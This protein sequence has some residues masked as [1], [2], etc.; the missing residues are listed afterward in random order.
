MGTV[1]GKEPSFPKQ[2][3]SISSRQLYNIQNDLRSYF[4]LIDVR[5]YSLFDESHIDMAVNIQTVKEMVLAATENQYRTATILYGDGDMTEMATD[6]AKQV[7]VIETNDQK[8]TIQDIMFLSDSFNDYKMLYPFL[9]TGDVNYSES[10][11]YPSQIDDNVFLSNYG[12]ASNI[13]VIATLGITHIVNCTVDCPFV[14]TTTNTASGAFCPEP[15]K[16]R[17]PVVDDQDQQICEHFHKALAF[18][19]D[20]LESPPGEDLATC[21]V[22]GP[23]SGRVLVHCKHGQSRSATVAAAWLIR[24][25]GHTVDSSIAYLKLCRPKVGPNAGFIDQ[26]AAF[27]ASL[28]TGAELAT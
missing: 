4:V 1:F 16:L 3:I 12:V 27:A 14:D 9:C 5:K 7:G 8:R 24:Y 19:Q 23:S 20:A 6:L 17:V 28:E 15:Q 22:P 2:P 26:L 21:S 13:D 10:R 18:M 11:L 25:R